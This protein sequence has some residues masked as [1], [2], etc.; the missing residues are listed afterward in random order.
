MVK[1][2][3]TAALVALLFWLLPAI[4]AQEILVWDNDNNSD[5]IDPDGAG[6]IGCEYGIEQALQENG[7]EYTSQ[8]NLP[9]D[10]SSYEVIF[11]TLGI[12]CTGCGSTPPGAVGSVEQQNLIQFLEA[13]KAIYIEGVDWGSDHS[14]TELFNYFGINFKNDGASIGIEDIV[15]VE[16]TFTAPNQFEYLYGSDADYLVDELAPAA[17]QMVLT[18]QDEKSRV[19]A[20]EADEGYR[21]ISSSVILGAFKD[22]EGSNTK[23]S[24]MHRYLMFLT[25]QEVPFLQLSNSEIDFGTTYSGYSNYYRLNLQNLGLETLEIS[26]LTVTGDGFS[27]DASSNME[28]GI[29]EETQVIIEFSNAEIGEFT[30][31][32]SF[33][34]NDPENSDVIIQ[35]SASNLLPPDLEVSPQ[36]VQ[37]ELETGLSEI[38][39]LELGNNG[40][41]QLDFS[42]E[43]I[44]SDLEKPDKKKPLASDEK[45]PKGREIYNTGDKIYRDF[46]GPDEFGYQWIDSDS[47]NGPVYQWFDIMNVGYD[48]G[49]TGD[50]SSVNIELPFEFMFYGDSKTSVNVF[51]NGYLSFDQA[52]SVYQNLPIPTPEQPNDIIAPFWDDLHQKNGSCY[53]YYHEA[54]NRF[55][56]QFNQW[57][58]YINDSP[59]TFQVILYENG[60][61]LFNYRQLNGLL[62]S[63]TIGIENY[64]GKDGL[65]VAY[66]TEYLHNELCVQISRGP[67]WLSSDIYSGILQ[68]GAN[69]I[70]DLTFDSNNMEPG[71]Y[72]ANIKITSNDPEE[73]IVEIPVSFTV[74]QTS[75]SEEIPLLAKVM[76]NYPNP[77]NPTTKIVFQINTPADVKIDIFNTKG[78]RIKTYPSTSYAKGENS[79]VWNGQDDNGNQVGSGIYFY[80]IRAGNWHK[81]QKM[82]L[83]K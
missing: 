60:T 45:M 72:S 82:L 43:I 44:D 33:T 81:T 65:Q 15:G 27:T 21:T 32:L 64:T 46:G 51:A 30:G 20:Y 11:V 34:T 42:L 16:G 52:N 75:N 47:P 55:I 2:Y 57:G 41:S 31:E 69:Q 6:N 38:F 26:N 76:G 37:V 77:F 58:F 28:I 1:S 63:T 3:K 29:G 13:G 14:D 23:A 78:Q 18:S 73:E 62:T 25:G 53:A 39:Q 80:R 12:W 49:L 24:L 22:A 36:Q 5:F 56:I 8:S 40:D 79:V 9:D 10:L 19:V 59:L 68:P 74:L 83:L 50:E 67:R 35:M 61:I 54:E 70:I 71:I 17:G 66:N 4:N 48:T 7:Y